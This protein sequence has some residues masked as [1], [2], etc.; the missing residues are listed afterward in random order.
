MGKTVN[1]VMQQSGSKPVARA[2]T[3]MTLA[4]KLATFDVQLHGGEAMPN[5]PQGGEA[6]LSGPIQEGPRPVQ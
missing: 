1:L 4:Q 3:E 2:S 5:A 6:W